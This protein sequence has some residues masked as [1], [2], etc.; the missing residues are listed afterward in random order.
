M[1]YGSYPES[2]RGGCVEILR[3][4]SRGTCAGGASLRLAVLFSGGISLVVL[5]LGASLGPAPCLRGGSEGRLVNLPSSMLI[6]QG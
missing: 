3:V 5:F 6:G 2:L 1:E 4:K